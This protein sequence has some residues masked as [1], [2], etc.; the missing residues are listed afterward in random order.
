MCVSGQLSCTGIQVCVFHLSFGELSLGD[1]RSGRTTTDASVGGEA[2]RPQRLCV[3]E[4]K[5]VVSYLFKGGRNIVQ[6]K[7]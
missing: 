4:R 5:R 3:Y 6:V 7:L 1:L 2:F